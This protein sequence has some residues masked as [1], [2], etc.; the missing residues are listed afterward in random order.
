MERD[1]V[2]HPISF[3]HFSLSDEILGLVFIEKKQTSKFRI[4]ELSISS[5]FLFEQPLGSDTSKYVKIFSMTIRS[6]A[7]ILLLG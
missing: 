3:V 7:T 6:T 2:I 1:Q 5:S 4:E